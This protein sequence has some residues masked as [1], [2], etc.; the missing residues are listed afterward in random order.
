[1][2]TMCN[3]AILRYLFPSFISTRENLADF[4]EPQVLPNEQEY[5]EYQSFNGGNYSSSI[6]T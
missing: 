1:M 5:Q 6:E 4:S 2:D 3:F